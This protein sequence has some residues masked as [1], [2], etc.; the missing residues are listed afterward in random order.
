[1]SGDIAMGGQLVTGLG[2]AVNSGD[3]VPKA[4]LMRQSAENIPTKT[5]DDQLKVRT[6]TTQIL[7]AERQLV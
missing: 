6:Y 4:V 3:A 1:M 5:T 7:E 2:T